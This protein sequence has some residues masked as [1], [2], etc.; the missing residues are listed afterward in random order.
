MKCRSPTLR[1]RYGA[2]VEIR[3]PNGTMD[4][5]YL[6]LFKSLHPYQPRK[7]PF[8][9]QVRYPVAFRLSKEV[10]EREGWNS[11]DFLNEVLN[12]A[13][14]EGGDF[15]VLVAALH[16]LE[17][18]PA[19][20]HGF[21]CRQ[22][23][24]AWWE[25]FS[26]KLG[27]FQGYQRIIKIPDDY[28]KKPEEKWPLILFLHGSGERGDD[29]NK[30]MDQGPLGYI[31]RGHPLPFVV[32]A[33]QCPRRDHWSPEK[34]NQLITEI[35]ATYRIDPKR[36]YVTG[37]S[38]GGYGTFDLAACF[39]ERLAAIAPVAGG[40]NPE[41]AERLKGVPTWIFHGE[42]D[43]AVPARYSVDMAGEMKKLGAEVTLT[44]YPGI[45]HGGWDKTYG[46][47]A[48]YDW[49]LQHPRP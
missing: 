21:S 24:D 17:A 25:G 47:P 10:L 32:V 36:I 39:P 5:R 2:W 20:W 35:E 13:Y 3:F 45:G 33:P 28:D 43:D 12:G 27:V 49:F 38:M 42:D 16:D 48:L 29:S 14:H 30:L 15:A 41:M 34:L 8:E 40:V 4:T 7:D 37:L 46:N 23:D 1:G 11:Q 19:R 26:K 9:L 31:N 6:T 18:E 22:I 44:L